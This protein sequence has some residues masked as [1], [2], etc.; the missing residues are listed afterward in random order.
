MGADILSFTSTVFVP[1]NT[2]WSGEL[3]VLEDRVS[4]FSPGCPETHSVH[5]ADLEL[6]DPPASA[7][8]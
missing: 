6:T 3:L 7:L 5:Q 1:I 4:L 2:F 8:D